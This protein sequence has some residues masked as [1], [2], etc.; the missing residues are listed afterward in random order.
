VAELEASLAEARAALATAELNLA[1]TTV[2][3]PVNGTAADVQ[4]RRGDY[5]NVG[6]PLFGI[7]DSGSLHVDGYFEETKLEN[8]HVGDRASIR[9]MGS[10][11]V[12]Y[13]RVQSISAGITD[14]ERSAS[15][16]LLPNVNPTFSYVR[17][18]QRIPVRIQLDSPPR[19][20]RLI[21]G[22][23]ATVVIGDPKAARR[24]FW[25]W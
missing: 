19:D 6:R 1:R 12:L 8:I 21:A 11:Q 7:V 24:G 22:R 10:S 20:V 15:P 14:R 18:A 9:L 4:L 17:L 3:A 13:G 23:T 5:A 16:N 2:R 25:S